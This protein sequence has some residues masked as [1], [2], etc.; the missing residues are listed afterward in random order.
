[1][2]LRDRVLRLLEAQQPDFPLTR[3]RIAAVLG[4][5]P[6]DRQPLRG[7][8]DKLEEEGRVITARGG[9]LARREPTL[10]VGTFHATRGGFGFVTPDGFA[11]AERDLFIPPPCTGGALDGD[12]VKVRAL[13]RQPGDRGPEGEVLDI[14]ARS[15]RPLVGIV[16]GGWLYPLGSPAQPV[17][18]PRGSGGE[19]KIALARLSDVGGEPEAETLSVLGEFR[20]IATALKAAE[21]RFQLSHAFPEKALEEVAHLPADPDPEEFAG[22][23]DYRQLLTVTIDPDDAKDF[24]DALS[25]RREGAG[26]KLWV[27]IAD[28]GHYVRPGSAVDEEALRRGNTTYLPT[29]AYHMLPTALSS[30]LC[31]LLEGRP[32]LTLTAEMEVD[33]DGVVQSARFFKGVIQSR[34]RL[35]YHQAQA[36]LEGKATEKREIADLLGELWVLARALTERREGRGSLDLELPEPHLVLSA[37]GEVDEIEVA[38]R[39]PSH[40]IVEECMLLANTAAA[41]RLDAEKAPALYRVHEVPDPKRLEALRPLLVALGLGDAARGDLADP[42]I[43]QQVLAR[44]RGHRAEKLV[45]YLIL[46]GMAQARYSA[47]LGGHFGLGL[48][49]YTHFTSPI[50]RYPDLLVHRALAATL[51]AGPVPRTD[52]RA[53]A[54]HCSET[55]RLADEAERETLRWLQLAWLSRRV[56]DE[57]EGVILGFGKGVARV[58]LVEHL[59]EA[60]CPF[61]LVED[62]RLRVDPDGMRVRGIYSGAVLRVGD[63][64]PVR[65]VRVDPTLLEAHVVPEPWPPQGTSVR[66]KRRR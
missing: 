61:R 47:D 41:Q 4:L 43:L 13:P 52:W 27:H 59:I 7:I 14:V 9:Y 38:E 3:S 40:R 53:A 55:E 6:R 46:R 57:F 2:S 64:L 54:A 12:R 31:S 28:V 24:D 22:R 32:R 1:M 39:L 44:A 30:G 33:R 10:V 8:L 11:V 29:T 51:G 26:W 17:A 21:V 5:G 50:R 66:R 18:L 42:E 49:H 20:D 16:R 34:R 37:S 60:V 19:G 58:E 36:M 65:L 62:D 35:T 63:R 15:E 48:E 25:L 23:A 45:S 56:G